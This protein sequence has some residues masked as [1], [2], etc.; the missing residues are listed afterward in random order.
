MDSEKI[1]LTVEVVDAVPVT[2]KDDVV[3]RSYFDTRKFGKSN[4]GHD[5][6]DQLTETEKRA[7]LEYLKSL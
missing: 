2:E 5:F 1:G 7:V 4:R 6:P 3:R